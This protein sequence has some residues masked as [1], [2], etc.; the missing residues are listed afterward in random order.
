MKRKELQTGPHIANIFQGGA[1]AIAPPP[2]GA[3]EAQCTYKN[4]YNFRLFQK[5]KYFIFNILAEITL[6]RN[7]N[8][9]L[10]YY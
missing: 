9:T 7:E 5:V 3:Y 6:R 1:S 2:A 10:L 4:R 8:N